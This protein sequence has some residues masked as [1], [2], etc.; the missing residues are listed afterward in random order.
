MKI[1]ELNSYWTSIYYHLHYTHQEKITHQ[2]IRLL[3]HID[4]SSSVGIKEIA[5]YLHVSH[6]TAS[7]HVKRNIDK[8]YVY[9]NRDIHDERKV[10]LHL[11]EAGK[12]LLK[13]NSSL[14][15]EKVSA[16]L[17][18]MTASEKQ[19]IQQ[20]FQLLSERAKHV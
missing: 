15:E 18:E 14:D 6:N 3:Q 19:L 11:T 8:G 1:E 17:R 16:I 5:D 10:I 12:D 7:E 9:K 4:K 13:R 2:T 20:A